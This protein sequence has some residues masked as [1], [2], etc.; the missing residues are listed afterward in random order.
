MNAECRSIQHQYIGRDRWEGDP[1]MKGM[2]GSMLMIVRSQP[3]AHK[4]H[5]DARHQRCK[6]R[7]LKEIYSKSG[8]AM[9]FCLMMSSLL[10]FYE[11][12]F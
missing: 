6:F 2:A 3:N 10:K 4:T 7:E 1:I 12:L 11:H 9:N 8:Y 5:R